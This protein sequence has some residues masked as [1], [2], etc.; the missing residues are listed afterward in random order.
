MHEGNA[1]N[2]SHIKLSISPKRQDFQTCAQNNDTRRKESGCKRYLD[3]Q[4]RMSPLSSGYHIFAVIA[5][6][7]RCMKDVISRFY[8]AKKDDATMAAAHLFGGIINIHPSEDGNG[9]ICHL[10]MAHALMQVKCSLFPVL[11]S[12]FQRYCTRLVQ[13]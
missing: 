12:S 5:V 11:L 10:I 9:K 6:I 1:L 4:Y 2:T 8:K 13:N 3:C 7:E